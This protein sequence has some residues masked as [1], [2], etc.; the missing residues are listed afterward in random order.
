MAGAH[1]ALAPSGAEI[2]LNCPGSVALCAKL[3]R[4]KARYVMVEGTVAHA[5]CEEYTGGKLT[6]E[7]LTALE[8]TTRK[9]EGFDV[10]I[11]EEMIS[12]VFE[13][14]DTIKADVE[15][16]K[17]GNKPGRSEVCV[18]TEQKVVMSSVDE[19]VW[20]KADKIIYRKGDRVKVYDFKYGKGVAVDA[21]ENPQMGIYGVGALD[22]LGI[23]RSYDALDLTI[24]QPRAPHA[25]G[26][27]RTW[28][29][30][31]A[32][33]AAF[34]A[35]VK[36]AVLATRE[37]N[38][39][40]NPGSWCRWC[41]ANEYASCNAIREEVQKQA[42]VTFDVVPSPTAQMPDVMAMPA[43]KLVLALRYRDMVKGFFKAM[44][45]R[46]QGM[47]E[48]GE[49]VPGLK[50]V[51]GR[52]TREWADEAAV[53]A[54]YGPMLGDK[55]FKREMLSPAGLEKVIGKGKK[56]AEEMARLVVKRPGAKTIAWDTDPRPTAKGSAQ[57]MFGV[58]PPAVPAKASNDALMLE[59]MGNAPKTK[60]PIW[61]I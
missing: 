19:A 14:A 24:V 27:T 47:L 35:K 21:E 60:G 41:P 58:I 18:L 3:P 16:M 4:K 46:L 48:A 52:S 51:D 36:A 11:T 37:P 1:S 57:E 40:C 23:G 6:S 13:W 53:E 25:D 38:A 54:S 15:K 50:L 20:G 56:T 5:L 39:P 22:T 31:R 26:G 10:T 59:L 7:A 32:W 55:L 43:E 49:T 34:R 17:G 28:T 61:P 9:Q 8:G 42:G 33:V 12:A 45:D 2:W 29:A 44:E 30:D